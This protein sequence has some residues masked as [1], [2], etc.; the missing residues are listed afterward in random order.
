MLAN[1]SEQGVAVADLG[2][3]VETLLLS[4]RT[5]P[6]RTSTESSATTPGRPD[7]R[8]AAATSRTTRTWARR[9]PS[10]PTVHGLDVDVDQRTAELADE[11]GD[12]HLSA[13]R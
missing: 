1:G 8:V 10:A 6:A 5:T 2:D 3:D 9:C 4:S 7:G 12:E 13:G 11:I